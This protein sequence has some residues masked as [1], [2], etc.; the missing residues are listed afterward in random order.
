MDRRPIGI[1]DS[2]VGGLTV[3][4]QIKNLLPD[5][6]II[7]LGDTKHLPYGDKSKEA[8]IRF[9]IENS[10]FLVRYGV[11]AIV[12]ACNSAS[13]VAVETLKEM[14]KIPIIDVIEPT[15]ECIS[16]NPPSSILIIGTVRTIA[17][18]V[19]A[20]KVSAI[21]T[22]IK[23]FGKACPLFVPLVEE[24]AFANKNTYLYKSLRNAIVHYLEEF[25]G[26]VNSVVLGCTHYPLIKD[27]IKEFMG[28]VKLI[29]PGECAGIKLKKVLEEKNML[30]DGN[31]RT[32]KFFV[33]DLSERV[34][35]VAQVI[36]NDNIDIE[37]VYISDF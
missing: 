2:G 5:E 16:K 24:G 32:E 17:S 9:S 14:F 23:V 34:R 20:K 35:Q 11:K 28:N 19:F 1:F 4:K 12:I 25:R 31:E 8:I 21:D 37:E 29:D 18:G 13:S 3:L 33:T 30:S 26:K 27:E 36:L 22:N 15:V 7:Y 10:K 6:S